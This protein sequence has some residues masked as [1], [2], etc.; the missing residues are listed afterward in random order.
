MMMNDTI[1]LVPVSH[2]DLDYLYDLQCIEGIRKFALN[3]DTPSYEGHIKWF[4]NKL[5]DSNSNFFK[6]LDDHYTV[7]IVRLD[8]LLEESQKVAEISLTID[9][10][11]AGKGYAKRSIN[12]IV[13]ETDVNIFHAVI[14]KMN[15][16]SQKV[17]L[18]NGFEYQSSYRPNFDLYTYC[19]D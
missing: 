4:N 17:F 14:H 6:V 19:K 5:N 9:P 18:A 15:I 8:F 12:K 10:E 7:G 2:N 3:A 11:Y 13:N 1:V 16:A